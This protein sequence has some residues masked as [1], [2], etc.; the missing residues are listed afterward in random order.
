MTKL[1][2][3]DRRSVLKTGAMLG[4]TAVFSPPILSFAQ[5]E[6]PIK[7][8]MHDPFTGTYAAEGESEKRGAQMA[9]AEVNAKGGILGRKVQLVT[10]DE[11]ANAGLAAQKAHKLI[12][13]DKVDFLMG[14]VSSATA[15]S[16]NQVAHEKGMLYMVTG[17]HTDPV[18]GTQC[19]W[20]TFRICTTTY[21]LAAGLAATLY[22]KF[23]GK[24][25][26]ITPDYAFGHTLQES[27]AKLLKDLG[28]TVLGNSLSP[29]G[30]TDFSSYLIKAQQS[31]PDVLIVL[32]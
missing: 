29:L 1:W 32:V 4:A 7:I 25:Y 16:V 19:H 30:T 8:G 20:T 24:W 12:E 3:P 9:L 21:M 28:G 14:A 6:T 23:G 26:F 18:T 13:Q 17:G 11:G 2:K 5:G 22:K 10:E 15:L 27:Y 31:K